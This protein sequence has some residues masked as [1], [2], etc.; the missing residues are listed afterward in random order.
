MRKIATTVMAVM[1]IALSTVSN[2]S[3]AAD[4][5]V[6]IGVSGRGNILD[7]RL[8]GSDSVKPVPLGKVPVDGLDLMSYVDPTAW[9]CWQG[10][11]C[12]VC[13]DLGTSA[14]SCRLPQVEKWCES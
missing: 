7:V 9:C 13:Q 8:E 3:L 14:A 10:G 2:Q 5:L 1:V 12:K 6:G 4:P 11:S